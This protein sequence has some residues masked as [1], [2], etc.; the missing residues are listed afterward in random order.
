MRWVGPEKG[1]IHLALSA[2]AN[3]IWDL[4]AKS[5]GK[6]VWKLVC[7]MTPEEYVRCVDFRYISDALSPAEAIE[8]LEEKQKGKQTRLEEATDNTAVPIYTT[9]AA[10]L[11]YSDEKMRELLLQSKKDGFHHYKLKIGGD[12]E[13]DLRR[14]KIFR[15]VIGW[16]DIL[17]LDSNQI[18]SVPEVEA[19]LAQLAHFKP[20]FIE[21]PTSPDDILG[22]ARI[23]ALLQK[24]NIAVATGEHCQNRVIFKQLLQA[25]A[26]DYCQ[27]DA[28]RLGGL[29]EVMAVMLL[30]AKFN[31]PIHPHMY[32]ILSGGVGLPEYSQHVST[33]DYVMVSGQKSVLEY[34]DSLHEHFYHPAQIANGHHI[35]PISPGYSVEIKPESMDKY[36]F[37]GENGSWWTTKE[38]HAMIN[39][40]RVVGWRPHTH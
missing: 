32:V 30:A 21:E 18:W 5:V 36:S 1:V 13:R 10:W 25:K 23:R 12:I 22:H 17:M 15:E 2:V 35:T 9:S 8:L 27:I 14:L 16:D 38:A 34:I 29:N 26:I 33:I 37:P 11:G 3:A 31:T 7:D 20:L 6:P 28:C 40:E 39:A 4:W 24:H 19:Y